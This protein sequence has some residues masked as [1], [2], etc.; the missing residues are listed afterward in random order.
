MRA[1]RSHPVVPFVLTASCLAAAPPAAA[2]SRMPPDPADPPVVATYSIVGFDP[3]TGDLGIAV[4]SK[5]FAVGAVVPWA[6][7]G[8]G[9][10]ATQ[11]SANTSFGPRGLDLL[12]E[13]NAPREVLEKLLASDP[14]STR[15]QV[16]IVDAKGRSAGFTGG[17]CMAWAGGMAGQNYAAQGNILVG[18]AT[19]RAL[20]ETF[21][22]AK[23]PLAD[24]LVAAL[25][26]G[27]AAG[28]DARGMESAALLVVRAGGGY[29]GYNDRYID[30]RVDDAVDPI[31][32]LQRLLKIQHSIGALTE[33][34]NLNKK[35][36]LAGAVAA[37]ERAVALDP[38]SAD[39]AYDL[40]CYYALSGR[41]T[42]ALASL[43]RAVG[44]NP[45]LA[46]MAP[47]DPDLASIRS[48][49]GYKEIVGPK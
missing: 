38:G 16:G 20:A 25:A 23:G 3:E 47:T 11:A 35:G 46:A 19:V 24:R 14:D 1:L 48:A 18:E 40:A 9:A 28:G 43:K 6:R 15:R 17:E 8:V 42:D 34:M 30:L 5:F 45:R 7:A 33:A 21:Q 37:A 36:D 49:P 41:T 2:V 26:A 44:L 39:C 22:S 12:A 31:A 4:Q 29:G 13:G 10:V 27:Q 32:E